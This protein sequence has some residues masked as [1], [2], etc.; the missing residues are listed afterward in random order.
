MDGL[1]QDTGCVRHVLHEFQGVFGGTVAENTR[2]IQ[3]QSI[4]ISVLLGSTNHLMALKE[5]KGLVPRSQ[6][7]VI[8][9]VVYLRLHERVLRDGA[10][11]LCG[12]LDSLELLDGTDLKL[13]VNKV[14][15]NNALTG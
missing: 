7:F 12:L 8:G 13:C 11:V 3:G 4:I 14:G 6:L 1:R 9:G 10:I 2:S 15:G 5:L